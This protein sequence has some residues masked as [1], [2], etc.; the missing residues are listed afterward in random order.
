MVSRCELLADPI[1]D[2]YASVLVCG[3]RPMSEY[4][5]E[6]E[7]NIWPNFSSWC[8]KC[9]KPCMILRGLHEFPVNSALY[10]HQIVV[11]R[12]MR[13]FHLLD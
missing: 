12:N 11:W 4:V 10:A 3:T 13:D 1:V 9:R 6:I 2:S 5:S 8:L 7:S